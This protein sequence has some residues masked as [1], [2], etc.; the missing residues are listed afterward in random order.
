VPNSSDVD[1]VLPFT[2]RDA[3]DIARTKRAVFGYYSDDEDMWVAGLLQNTAD[4]VRLI[5]AARWMG[6]AI[7]GIELLRGFGLSE[8]E[9]SV[10]VHI[11]EAFK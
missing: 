2:K 10:F 1:E 5:K 4:A 9:R 11:V 8:F 3:D 6:W 7:V